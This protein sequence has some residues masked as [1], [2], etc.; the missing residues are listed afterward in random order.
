MKWILA[1]GIAALTIDSPVF[2][3]DFEFVTSPAYMELVNTPRKLPADWRGQSG[4]VSVNREWEKDPGRKWFVE[5][6]RDGGRW[7]EAGLAHRTGEAVEW[8]LKQLEWGFSRMKTEGSFDCGDAFHSASFLVETTARSILLIEASPMAERFKVRVDGLKGPLLKCALW[9]ASPE[10]FR[11]AEK[12]RIY[13]HRR[14][15]LGCGLMQCAMI[16]GNGELRR[17]AFYFIEDGIRMQREDGAFPEKG[18]HD[19]SYHAVAL[20][21]LQRLLLVTPEDSR[22]ATWSLAA[23]RGVAWLSSRIDPR[24][25]VGVEGNTRTGSGQEVGRTGVP[26]KVNRSEVATA[27]LYQCHLGGGES[28]EKLAALVL[29][30]PD[31]P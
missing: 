25:V 20:I 18:G 29:R 3:G 30:T 23:R 22:P 5:M 9:M 11:V 7:V 13:G 8:G 17:V 21:Y 24:G 15:L 2:A 19:S 6:Q 26:K 14:F 16:H 12:Q 27:L 31:G 4:A 28:F 1:I 10:N